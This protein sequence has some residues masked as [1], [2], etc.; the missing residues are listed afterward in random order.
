MN[1]LP[2]RDGSLLV[3][4]DILI[5]CAEKGACWGGLH[6]AFG[7]EDGPRTVKELAEVNDHFAQWCINRFLLPRPHREELYLLTGYS[8]MHGGRWCNPTAYHEAG[9]CHIWPAG[10]VRSIADMYPAKKRSAR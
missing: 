4:R 8:R 2:K 5:R 10:H 7:S 3:T 1:R 9:K 6:W